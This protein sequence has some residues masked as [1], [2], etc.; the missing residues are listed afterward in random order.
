MPRNEFQV[1]TNN[2][3]PIPVPVPSLLSVPLHYRFMLLAY[4]CLRYNPPAVPLDYVQSEMGSHAPLFL[5]LPWREAN[6]DLGSLDASCSDSRG[7]GTMVRYMYMDEASWDWRV[8]STSIDTFSSPTYLFQTAILAENIM[9][10]VSG[11]DI[12]IDSVIRQVLRDV[13][14]DPTLLKG[15]MYTVRHPNPPR[16]TPR[17]DR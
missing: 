7:R 16:Q 10:T 3:T 6:N 14:R 11:W 12:T 2:V 5:S 1:P 9:S 17:A 13:K 15:S 8:Q 4:M